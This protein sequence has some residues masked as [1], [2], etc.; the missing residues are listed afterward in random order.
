MAM[1]IDKQ[2]RKSQGVPNPVNLVLE[3][4][5]MTAVV[6]GA[7]NLIISVQAQNFNTATQESKN[8]FPNQGMEFHLANSMATVFYQLGGRLEKV[9]QELDLAAASY[10]EEEV[11]VNPFFFED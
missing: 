10:Y 1:K 4:H 6:D 5:G 7:G 8:S 9:M 2:K 3:R 11:A